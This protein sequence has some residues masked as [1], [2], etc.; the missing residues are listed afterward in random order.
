MGTPVGDLEYYKLSYQ[1]QWLRPMFGNS[2]LMLNGEIGWGGGLGD[3]DLPFF[4]NFYA[5]GIG[6]VR[7]FDNGT[8]G[9]KVLSSGDVISIGGDKRLVGNAE[10]MFPFPGADNDRSL[11]MSLFF[12]VG[13]VWGPNDR[14]GNYKDISFS[15]MRYSA[16]LAVTWL[17]PMGPIKLSLAKPLRSMPDDKE[18]AFQFQLGQVF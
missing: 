17:S 7:G 13:G 15:E 4:R 8:L 1:Y 6:S 5:G 12:D 11:R 14:A 16:G 2:T 18:Q 3:Q 10:L 9:P